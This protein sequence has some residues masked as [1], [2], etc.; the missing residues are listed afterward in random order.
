MKL[1]SWPHLGSDN[2]RFL[3]AEMDGNGPVLFEYDS[4]SEEWQS[5]EAVENGSGNGG[6]TNNSAATTAIFL[7]AFN[8]R[9][10]SV[11]IA[12]QPHRDTPPL[13]LRPI[14]IGGDDDDDDDGHAIDRLHVYG[15]GKVMIIKSKGVE[16]EERKR[17]VRMLK[18]VELWG[19]SKN[20]RHWELMSRVPISLVEKIKK[21]YGAMMGCLELEE[22]VGEAM[23]KSESGYDTGAKLSPM[24]P[25]N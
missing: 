14:F 23:S 2:F 6:Q 12:K 22:R 5:T 20:G 10:G 18:S 11:V 13:V 8:G 7:S 1:L 17:R 9:N 4:R 15:D 21:P 24:S 3:F 16:E 25:P 19:L